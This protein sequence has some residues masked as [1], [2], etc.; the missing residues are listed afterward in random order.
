MKKKKSRLIVSLLTAFIMAFTVI[1][2]MGHANE[3]NAATGDTVTF[4]FTPTINNPISKVVLTQQSNGNYKVQAAA[5]CTLYDSYKANGKAVNVSFFDA[6]KAD[7]GKTSGLVGYGIS[8]NGD[9]YLYKIAGTGVW[10]EIEPG[11]TVR[12]GACAYYDYYY[13]NSV[14]APVWYDDTKGYK[15]KSQYAVTFTAPCATHSYSGGVCTVCGV[16]SGDLFKIAG[17]RTKDVKAA[18]KGQVIWSRTF[19]ADSLKILYLEYNYVKDSG[20]AW[21]ADGY[22]VVTGNSVGVIH[23][24][25]AG[26]KHKVTFDKADTYTV[27]FKS[28]Y[29]SSGTVAWTIDAEL[30]KKYVPSN[31]YK[32]CTM[33]K[34]KDSAPNSHYVQIEAKNLDYKDPTASVTSE[35]NKVMQSPIHIYRFCG[36]TVKLITVLEGITSR[37]TSTSY[38]DYATLDKTYSYYVIKKCMVDKYLSSAK[39][40]TTKGSSI[41]LTTDQRTALTTNLAK[42]GNKAVVAGGT[43]TTIT[44]PKP[45]VATVKDFK[46]Y[47]HKDVPKYR[48]LMWDNN[49]NGGV[50]GYIVK[51]YNSSGKLIKNYGRVEM[52]AP[53]TIGK[54]RKYYVPYSSDPDKYTAYFTV[55]PYYK[56]NGNYYNGKETISLRLNQ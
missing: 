7:A 48:R 35:Q 26:D 41:T 20:Y 42:Y 11:Q 5:K 3:A 49:S 52:S 10:T 47:V 1:P 21:P 39:L 45:T 27:E 2:F 43:A 18:D 51:R 13:E 6:D 9:D 44:M 33:T 4:T 24:S 28:N 30:V 36:N 54:A 34:L 12:L 19:K 29:I 14:G 8:Q 38:K 46:L 55:T 22:F 53:D 16:V 37:A 31:K 17:E 40:P 23:N 56:Y 32:T 50:T 25:N 15:A